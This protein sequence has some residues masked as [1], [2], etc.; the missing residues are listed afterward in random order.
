MKDAAAGSP[1]A[2]G[3][4]WP[5]EWAPHRAT[6]FSWPH[7]KETWPRGLGPVEDAF[8]EIVRAILPGEAVEINVSD[9][10]MAER[11]RET[12]IGAGLD[13]ES[14]GGVRFHLHPTDDAWVRDHGAIFLTGGPGSAT[15]D[16]S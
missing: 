3:Y 4:R 11:V 5:A 2:L 8:C 6:W 7:N 12:L 14:G 10:A 13:V 1:A 15:A 16:G 9:E